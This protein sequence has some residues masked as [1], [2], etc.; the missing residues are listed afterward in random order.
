[1]LSRSRLF[2]CRKV[3]AALSVFLLFGLVSCVTTKKITYFQPSDASVD[4]LAEQASQKYIARIAPG[5]ILSITVSSIDS[6]ASAMFNPYTLAQ[7]WN[8]YYSQSSGTINTAPIVGYNV[9][10]DGN[11]VV[12]QLG[13]VQ[14]SGKTSRQLA[15]ELTI[16]LERYLKSP[17][18][19]VRIAN[20]QISVL[21]EVMR[22]AIYTISNERITL[23]EALALAGDVTLYGK[24]TDVTI[25]RE[26]DGKRE[27]A[28]IDLTSRAIFDSPYYNLQSGDIIY[29]APSSG[30]TAASDRTL[31]LAPT[32]ISSLTLLL[33]VF[34]AFN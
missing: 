18:V 33:M 9:D 26:K 5:D 4:R 25:I 1:M 13:K 28:R 24:R 27:F 30:K 29:V 2:T 17:T 6:E 12:P 7:T 21:G 19:A 15:D 32:V 11:I 23:P 14:A 22:P 20:Y 10:A 8:G 3:A 31:Q 16:K 34:T